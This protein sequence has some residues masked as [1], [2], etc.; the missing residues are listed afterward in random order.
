MIPSELCTNTTVTAAKFVC[1]NMDVI[2]YAIAYRWALFKDEQGHNMLSPWKIIRNQTWKGIE[3]RDH[4]CPELP[5]YSYTKLYVCID[6]FC[7]SGAYYQTCSVV[8]TLGDPN[9]FNKDILYDLNINSHFGNIIQAYKHSE[10]IG[11]K[12][13]ELHDSEMDFAGQDVEIGGYI[14][15]KP[16]LPITCDGFVIDENFPTGGVV[17]VEAINGF[18]IEGS[19]MS[20]HW[21]GFE[22][23]KDALQLGYTSDMAGYKYAIGSSPGASDVLGFTTVGLETSVVATDILLR[24]GQ[25]YFVTVR[26][27]NHR[28]KTVDVYSDGVIYD[29]S[30][31]T[32]G[33]IQVESSLLYVVTSYEISVKWNEIE[34]NESG[35]RKI[36]IGIGSSN[37]SADII[38]FQEFE[39]YG[40]I[41]TNQCIQDGHRYF[42]ILKATNGAGLSSFTVSSPFVIDATPPVGGHIMDVLDLDSKVDVDFQTETNFIRASWLGFRD[43]H[44]HV[45]YYK[46]GLGT[47]YGN[48]DVMK[49]TNVGLHTSKAWALSFSQGVTYYSTVEACNGAGLC[50]TAT[51]NG[52]LIDNSAPV[53]GLVFVGEPGKYTNFIS[54]RNTIHASWIGFEDPH[55]GIDHFDICLGSSIDTCDV[56]KSLNVQLASSI[57]K[58]KLNMSVGVDYFVSVTAC[59]HVNVCTKRSSPS[60]TVDNTP[61]VVIDKPRVFSIHQDNTTSRQII[62]DPSFFKV[63]WKFRDSESPIIK[64]ILT[65]HSNLDS[66]KPVDDIFISNE[67]EFVVQLTKNNLLRQGDIYIV[68]ITSCNAASMC[69]SAVSEEFL[70]DSTPPQMGGFRSPLEYE[71][72]NVTN[73][74][75]LNLSWY[76]F[77]D[78]ETDIRSYYISVGYTFSETQLV[79]GYKIVPTTTTDFQQSQ[80]VANMSDSIMNYL[81][82]TIWAENNAGIM[83]SQAKVTT[84]ILPNNYDRSNGNLLIQMH[85]CDTYFCEDDCRCDCTCG[86]VGRKCL[87]DD[88]NSCKNLTS[89]ITPII[90]VNVSVR[91][92]DPELSVVGSSRCL[93]SHWAYESNKHVIRFEYSFGI[94][95]AAIGLGVFNLSSENVWYDVGRRTEAFHCLLKT[96]LTHKTLYVAYVKAWTSLD[97]YAIFESDPVIIDHTPPVIHKKHFVLDSLLSCDHDVDYIT[98]NDSISAC[99]MGVFSEDESYIK[100]IMVSLG[101]SQ[102]GM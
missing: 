77:F 32:V 47:S 84:D 61:P 72:Q 74:L 45:I 96:Q 80:I 37:R 66:H 46:I 73:K 68:Q 60:F 9:T 17:S 2:E 20:I 44:S 54:D 36:E 15:G 55:S 30:P 87:S 52:I 31:P 11:E 27:Y 43:P 86:V 13:S 78:V 4:F 70:V 92:D 59:N 88:R 71:I 41:S 14:L 101:T 33:I 67:G 82:L 24:A 98:S 53:P 51:S 19:T 76:G 7:Q 93:G 49:L 97:E 89:K 83:T 50:S 21:T 1:S 79:D 26:A 38:P 12:L 23:S 90:I 16:D 29:N 100:T 40:L 34:D 99:W 28:N 85:S 48:D 10:N 42:A 56:M 62:S 75:Y 81:V 63:F 95:G 69:T 25:I 64:T 6:S 22:G 5:V 94:K 8:K 3:I 65:I 58:T 91:T 102:N 57:I 18:I 39:N 35:I